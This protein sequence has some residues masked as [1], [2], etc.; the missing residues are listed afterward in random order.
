MLSPVTYYLSG[1]IYGVKCWF[2]LSPIRE[3]HLFGLDQEAQAF[4]TFNF[5]GRA[6]SPPENR[7]ETTHHGY[8][9]QRLV[10]LI[11]SHIHAKS[12]KDARSKICLFS[13]EKQP[14]TN[15][16]PYRRVNCR[17]SPCAR[18]PYGLLALNLC[19]DPC[20]S[21]RL[22]LAAEPTF[23]LN[24]AALLSRFKFTFGGQLNPNDAA[25][26]CTPP[27]PTSISNLGDS[28][29]LTLTLRNY[30]VSLHHESNPFFANSLAINTSK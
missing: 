27:D 23:L 2:I 9:C 24:L 28:H 5:F 10:T 30:T 12:T 4:M 6:S 7:Q 13:R 17:L 16:Y 15:L 25:T 1:S 8:S 20:P 21:G 18:F 29:F 3:I 19:P 14:N 22:P 26:A 11:T